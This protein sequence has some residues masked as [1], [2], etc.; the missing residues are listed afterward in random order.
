MTSSYGVILKKLSIIYHISHDVN[1]LKYIII[2]A[3]QSITVATL[4]KLLCGF[5]KKLDIVVFT[6]GDL[7][8]FKSL[9]IDMVR[10]YC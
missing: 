5:N 7:F 4:I 8:E 6:R 2:A 1:E 9:S 3:V 10:H